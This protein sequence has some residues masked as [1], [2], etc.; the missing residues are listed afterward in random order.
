MCISSLKRVVN[1]KWTLNGSDSAYWLFQVFEASSV[2]ADTTHRII[3][4]AHQWKVCLTGATEPGSSP[5]EETTL[6]CVETLPLLRNF[7][8]KFEGWISS[9]PTA[10]V[11]FFL[12]SSGNN[13]NV[14]FPCDSFTS[15]FWSLVC[16]RDSDH[17]TKPGS[18]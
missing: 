17:F 11:V 3:A 1:L 12:D 8:V 16:C 4:E 2:S 7:P 10:A 5:L 9:T 6:W 15:D 18:T 13:A 14:F